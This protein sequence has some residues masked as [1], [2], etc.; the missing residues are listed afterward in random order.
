MTLQIVILQI[1]QLKIIPMCLDKEFGEAETCTR[2]RYILLISNNFYWF[3]TYLNWAKL[4]RIL[5]ELIWRQAV[6]NLTFEFFYFA[7]P[8]FTAEYL[9]TTMVSDIRQTCPLNTLGHRLAKS[10]TPVYRYTLTERPSSPVS[11]ESVYTHTFLRFYLLILYLMY[12]YIYDKE[13]T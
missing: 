8:N 9:Y 4:N 7:D 1:L 5:Y 12:Y 13:L 2:F 11:I 10:R 3:E 6:L